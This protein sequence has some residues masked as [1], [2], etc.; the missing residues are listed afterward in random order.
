MLQLSSSHFS[1]RGMWFSK[2]CFEYMDLDHNSIVEK[3]MKGLCR[4]QLHP[5]PALT[6][7]PGPE[8]T[9]RIGGGHREQACTEA[10]SQTLELEASQG[11]KLGRDL[12]VLS[13]G[14]VLS[15]KQSQYGRHV[16]G[17][18]N[19][20]CLVGHL[21]VIEPPS[22][23]G[24]KFHSNEESSSCF[25]LSV[26]ASGDRLK[27]CCCTRNPPLRHANRPPKRGKYHFEPDF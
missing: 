17:A 27:L 1:C 23:V 6:Q 10:H 7:S 18:D 21:G 4:H 22:A 8:S 25:D 9:A 2:T 11:R 20:T 5:H 16:V 14:G 13:L 24:T 19:R 12:G 15:L 3:L 26:R